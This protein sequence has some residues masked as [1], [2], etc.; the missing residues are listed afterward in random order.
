[1]NI[2]EPTELLD[3]EGEPNGFVCRRHD[4]NKS[5]DTCKHCRSEP[6]VMA[7]A[8]RELHLFSSKAM[9]AMLV[10]LGSISSLFVFTVL[11]LHK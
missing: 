1:M 2:S 9:I 11:Y 7:W 3:Q 6:R 4:Q 10:A 8:C 5:Y